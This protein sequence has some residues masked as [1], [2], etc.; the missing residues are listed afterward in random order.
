M[1]PPF[2]DEVRIRRLELGESRVDLLLRRHASGVAVNV[3][4]RRGDARVVVVT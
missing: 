3:L 1:L 4:A 2:V